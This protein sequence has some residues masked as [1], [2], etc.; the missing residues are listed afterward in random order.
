MCK[1]PASPVPLLPSEH[2]HTWGRPEKPVVTGDTWCGQHPFV[3]SS[4]NRAL[5]LPGTG[6][7]LPLQSQHITTPP[8]PPT[9]LCFCLQMPGVGESA[10]TTQ[11]CGCWELRSQ[12]MQPGTEGTWFSHRVVETLCGRSWDGYLHVSRLIPWSCTFSEDKSNDVVSNKAV[13]GRGLLSRRPSVWTA[14]LVLR[15]ASHR[16]VL[17]LVGI[18][19]LPFA[20]LR[21]CGW[22]RIYSSY[23]RFY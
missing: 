19:T 8:P 10:D 23:S 7:Y 12:G 9:A 15:C 11:S 4:L 21:L 3:H 14:S 6:D 20:T 17:A 18:W 22:V 13:E 5:G 16:I 1:L 2:R